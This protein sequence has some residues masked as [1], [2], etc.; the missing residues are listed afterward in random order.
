MT[1]ILQVQKHRGLKTSAI[2]FIF[3]LLIIAAES[4]QLYS[5]IMNEV[6]LFLTCVYRTTVH[7]DSLNN[8]YV[9]RCVKENSSFTNL[10]KKKKR[11]LLVFNIIS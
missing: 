7:C 2:P 10:K 1:A 9:K 8:S 3:W 5:Y 11:K 4:L 6:R